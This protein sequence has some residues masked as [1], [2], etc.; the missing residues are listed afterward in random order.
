MKKKILLG[1]GFVGMLAS[2]AQ[3]ALVVP[4][5]D[6]TNFENVAAAVLVALAVF[7]GIKKAISLIRG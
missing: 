3:A 6:V 5:L 1:L 4:T 7:W 2:Q